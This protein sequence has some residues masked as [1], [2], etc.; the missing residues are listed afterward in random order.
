MHSSTLAGLVASTNRY[1]LSR[2]RPCR[3]WDSYFPTGLSSQK[4]I[5]GECVRA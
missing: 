2:L 1:S 5:F 3:S 4:V